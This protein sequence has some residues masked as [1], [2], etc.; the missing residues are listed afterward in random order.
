MALSKT[1]AQEL[2]EL[3][4]ADLRC[5][6]AR[7]RLLCVVALLRELTDADHVLSNADLRAVLAARFGE[8]CAPA[9]NTLAADLRAIAQSGALDLRLHVTP[10]GYWC[11]RSRLT[12][13]KARLMLNAVQSSRFLTVRQSAELQED[14]FGLVS[15]YQEDDLAGQVHVDQ[16]VLKSYQEVFSALEAVTRALNTGKKVEFRYT[17][18]D[19]AGHPQALPGDNGSTLRVET[20]IALYFSENNYYVETYT[21]TPWR[22]DLEVVISRVD[23]MADVRVSE[24]D[25]DAGRQV[26]ELRRSAQR[27]MSRSFDM[28]SGPVRTVFVRVRS[29]RTNVLFDRFGFGMRFGQFEGTL[30]EPD[31][32]GLTLMHLPQTFTFYRWLSAAGD[33]IVIEEPPEELVLRSG[34][35]AP[36]LKDVPREALMADYQALVAGYLA[37]LDRARAPY[38]LVT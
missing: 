15:R 2:A 38:A 10:S 8:E 33:G 28:I 18:A 34:P 31:C 26:S 4:S 9:E 14:L 35:W 27:R 22:H 19:F 11:E 21:A 13:V 20:P 6:D 1:E 12:P 30:G 17:Y 37:Y 23:R 24:Q 32:T 16:R 25:A 36:A 7:Q 5:D 3:L 29:D